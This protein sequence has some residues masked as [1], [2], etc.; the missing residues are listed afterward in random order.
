MNDRPERATYGARAGSVELSDRVQVTFIPKAPVALSGSDVQNRQF[1]ANWEV[2]E[3]ADSYILDVSTENNFSSFVSGYQNL[4][5]AEVTS[6]TL[7]NMNPGTTYFYR[8]KAK[9]DALIGENS[10]TIEVT[11]FPDTP[12][13]T[14]ASD[15]SVVS[16]TANWETAEGAKNYRLDVARDQDFN[17]YVQGYE[18]L[19]VGNVEN[20]E[21]DG[22]L[23][24]RAFY[25]RVQAE[26]GPRLSNKSNI[27]DATTIKIDLENSEIK[28]EQ[29]RVL[30][31]GEQTNQI[32][33]TIRGE[34]GKLQE[35]VPV[36]LT[37]ENGQSEIESIRPVTNEEGVALFSILND[38]AETVTYSAK[39]ANE[40]LGSI[41]L[42]FLPNAN[43]L[44]LGNNFPNPFRSQS[45]IPFTIP[46]PMNVSLQIYNSIGSPVRTLLDETVETGYYEIPFNGTDLAAGV[47]FYR[48]HT[49]ERTKTG[50]MVLVK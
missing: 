9:S 2:E 25:Y 29:L 27:A 46:R 33:I 43:E 39:A 16:F 37:P 5:V 21:V 11:T 30:A 35:G 49:E 24:G 28:A 44:T 31:N 23:P 22:L 45:A 15:I 14:P 13:A 18:N 38:V 3:Y 7:T 26:S 50:K 20:Y 12:V 36:Q 41:S 40:D 19:D 48:L 10:E 4:D 17:N 6:Y 42:E 8:V 34:D 1:T 32:F 47:Y